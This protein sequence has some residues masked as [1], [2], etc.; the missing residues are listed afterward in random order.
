[1]DYLTPFAPVKGLG[2][3]F[4]LMIAFAGI[5]FNGILD[6]FPNVRIGFMEEGVFWLQTCLER[7]NQ[8]WET[9]IQ[10]DSRKE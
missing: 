10:Q 2:H 5:I 6:K 9:H 8:S 3:P 1:M 4:C 7:F